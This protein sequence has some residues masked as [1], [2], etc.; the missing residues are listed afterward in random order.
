MAEPGNWAVQP[1][2]IELMTGKFRLASCTLAGVGRAG[3]AG[4]WL[5]PK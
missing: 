5:R 4:A 1:V 3:F 2:D